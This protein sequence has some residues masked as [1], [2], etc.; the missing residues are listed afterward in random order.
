MKY[1]GNG[2]AS[3]PFG[4]IEALSMKQYEGAQLI[5]DALN[6]VADAIRETKSGDAEE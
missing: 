6:N 2:D 4:A 3:T 5:A 1:L